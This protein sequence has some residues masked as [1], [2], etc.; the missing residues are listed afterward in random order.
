[1]D[2]LLLSGASRASGLLRTRVKFGAD[3]MVD[4]SI[5]WKPWRGQQPGGFQIGH[6]SSLLSLIV[7]DQY[8]LHQ[9][10]T[11]AA[12]AGCCSRC[13]GGL[14]QPHQSFHPQLSAQ[15]SH[16][17]ITQAVVGIVGNC[18]SHYCW[19]RNQVL[20]PKHI[21]ANAHNKGFKILGS[22]RINTIE[23]V[24]ARNAVDG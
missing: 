22:V 5:S 11:S 15:R 9:Y 12:T 1:M 2:G 8:R 7:V 13:I 14:Y 16:S 10:T 20:R 4:L 17:E 18:C 24:S 21:L 6:S 23:R 19:R 3:K